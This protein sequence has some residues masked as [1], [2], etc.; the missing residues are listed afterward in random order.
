MVS[1]RVEGW[2][3]HKV[4]WHNVA[5]GTTRSFARRAAG[6]F[7]FR[8]PG[9]CTEIMREYHYNQSLAVPPKCPRALRALSDAGHAGAC[10]FIPVTDQACIV[11]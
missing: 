4:V 1:S 3:T 7:L 2:H 8:P 11:C 9:A 10:A 6:K 5:R